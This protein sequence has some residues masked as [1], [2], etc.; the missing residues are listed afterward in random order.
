M[1][2]GRDRAWKAGLLGIS[3]S[4]GS[5]NPSNAADRNHEDLKFSY[6]AVQRGVDIRQDQAI[7]QGPEATDAGMEGECIAA[8]N[9]SSPYGPW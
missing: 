8:R 3:D 2:R 9:G 5:S 4:S 6:L 7:R 1:A